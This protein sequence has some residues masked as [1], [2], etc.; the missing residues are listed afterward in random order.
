M[1]DHKQTE[2]LIG[3][4]PVTAEST[5]DD[6]VGPRICLFGAVGDGKS[7]FGNAILMPSVDDRL[8]VSHTES[9][10]TTK[11][12]T[13]TGKFLEN[14]DL[15]FIDEKDIENDEL[16]K[17]FIVNRKKKAQE[18]ENLTII[19]TPG[20]D[21][22][23]DLIVSI[24]N[25][26]KS[27]STFTIIVSAA[28]PRMEPIVVLIKKIKTYSNNHDEEWQNFLRNLSVVYTHWSY[29]ERSK[30]ERKKKGITKKMR[31]KQINDALK[32]AFGE[33][34]NDVECFFIDNE[35]LMDQDCNDEDD[36]GDD[37]DGDDNDAKLEA[38]KELIRYFNTIKNMPM[39][40][41]NINEGYMQRI[42][43]ALVQ[44]SG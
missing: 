41:L 18:I 6:S 20:F 15:L 3:D 26:A 8:Y 21:A 31:K 1:D 23:Y 25:H 32:K 22:N 36:D 42:L 39:F 13:K 5:I 29:D 9:S 28:N 12:Q 35:V 14:L 7:S 37:D 44:A 4:K 43:R 40:T 11:C 16:I 19:D 24:L 17:P 38:L 2:T 27:V 10:G 33:K 30:K 34:I